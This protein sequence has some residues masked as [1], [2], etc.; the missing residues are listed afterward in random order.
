MTP[1]SVE[2][3]G[4]TEIRLAGLVGVVGMTLG[5]VADL[6]SGYSLAGAV[7]IT[8]AF[9]VLSLENLAPFLV[10]K[11]PAQVV[12]GHYLAILAIPLG[13]FGLWQVYRAIEPAGPALSRAA[14]FL[15]VYAYVA[16]TVF[17]STFAFVTFGVQA[18]ADAPPA[19]QQAVGTMLD[20]FALVF[21]PLGVLLV[22]VMT[23]AFGLISVAIAFG[24]THYPRW[25]A[26]ANPLVIQAATGAVALVAPSRSGYSSSLPRTTCRW[27]RSTRSRPG[28]SG[29][30]RPSA[31]RPVA[32]KRRDPPF[33]PRRDRAARTPFRLDA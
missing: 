33:P 12:L 21:E 25:F 7:P 9:S 8:T 30:V 15:G 4:P 3:P 32:S 5:V 23:V 31:G 6:A 2:S 17:H 27:R 19:G 11:P 1:S 22:G 13:L 18:A 24:E 26:L 14:W 20:R 16:G 29:T 10:S 28:C